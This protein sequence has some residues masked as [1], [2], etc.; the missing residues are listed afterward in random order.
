M[1]T[2]TR[3]LRFLDGDRTRMIAELMAEMTAASEARE[4]ERA[5]R[6]RDQIK[7]LEALGK[8]AEAEQKWQESLK[9]DPHHPESTYNGGLIQWRSA[10]LTDSS[11]ECLST[12]TSMRFSP[13]NV[14]SRV[15]S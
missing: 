4:F 11:A 6:L 13:S 15:T 3:L 14:T 5:V 8:R 9:V 1:A 12:V 2:F 10:R 7:A